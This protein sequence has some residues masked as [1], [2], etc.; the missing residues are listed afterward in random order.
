[1]RKEIEEAIGAVERL[2]AKRSELEELGAN[3]AQGK[4]A[5]ITVVG[6]GTSDHAAIFARYLF[7]YV[8]KVPVALGAPSLLTAYGAQSASRGT[9]LIAY[10]QSGAGPDV[11]ALTAG[12]RSAGAFTVAVTNE[13]TSPLAVAA[14]HVVDLDAGAERAVAATK[15]YIAELVAT[16]LLANGAARIYGRDDDWSPRISAISNEM[17][18]ALLATDAWIAAGYASSAVYAMRDADRVLVATRGFQYPNALEF[19]LK[20]R[21]TTG[22]FANGFSAADLLHGPIASASAQTPAV[23]IDTDPATASSL[24]VVLERLHQAGTPLLRIGI[25]GVSSPTELTLPLFGGA[26]SVPATAISLLALVES[27]AV[28]RGNDPDAPKGLSKV[29]KT[30]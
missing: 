27:I 16:I 24:A 9:A 19:A 8:A 20:L 1:M 10:S 18:A 7:E 26:L 15:T 13:P 25:G 11:I 17:R 28:A 5:V 29:T 2:I 12:A 23:V 3:L 6:R 30:L 21:E 4:P 22:I 14:G